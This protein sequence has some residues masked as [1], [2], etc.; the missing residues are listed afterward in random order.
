ML[1]GLEADGD[2]SPIHRQLEEIQGIKKAGEDRQKAKGKKVK[3]EKPVGK[4]KA[5]AKKAQKGEE[6]DSSELSEE[7]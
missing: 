2:W 3:T 4:G 7:D 6:E 5:K 1:E